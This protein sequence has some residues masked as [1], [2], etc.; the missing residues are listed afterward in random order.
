MELQM[1]EDGI[2]VDVD[3][4][5]YKVG[6]EEVTIKNA[7]TQTQVDTAIEKRL[8]RQNEQIKTLEDQAT[9]TPALQA[10]IDKMKGEK[11]QMETD[12]AN[13]R[14]DA[15]KQVETQLSEANKARD[16]AL[17]ALDQEKVARVRDQVSTSIISHAK[18]DFID[19]GADIVPRLLQKHKREPVMDKDGKPVPGNFL[20]L[21][22]VTYKNDKNEDVTEML[23]VDKALDAIKGQEKYQHYVRGTATGG[24]GGSQYSAGPRT[25]TKMSQLL[26]R[27]DKV[28][29]VGKHGREA[30]EK[31][32]Q[33]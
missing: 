18:N 22:E 7:K 1:N 2:L 6:D 25:I 20:D 29:F 4:A 32:A 21:F 15:E 33:E 17:S 3:G 12:L 8:A 13:A 11:E 26:T 24:K 10:L 5:P 27:A 14:Q 30:F 9:K 23:P 28:A 31:L 19:P 16:A